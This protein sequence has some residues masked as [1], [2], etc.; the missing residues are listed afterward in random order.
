MKNINDDGY[1]R[2][3]GAIYKQAVTD[4]CREVKK[5][6]AQALADRKVDKYQI[7]KYLDKKDEKIKDSVCR[8]VY[9]E[10]QERGDGGL[11]RKMQKNAMA[12]IATGLVGEFG[13][14]R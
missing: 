5:R 3:Y 1:I 7:R 11:T 14:G 6:V 2:L 4:D 10:A 12:D 13:Q 9:R 8:A